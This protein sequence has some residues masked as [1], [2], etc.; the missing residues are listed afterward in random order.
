MIRT[1]GGLLLVM[2]GAGSIDLGG[3]LMVGVATMLTGLIVMHWGVK[4]L[5]TRF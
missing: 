5:D 2:G 4:N 3:S 1:M